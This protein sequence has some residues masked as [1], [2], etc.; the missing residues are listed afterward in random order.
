MLLNRQKKC[1]LDLPA[2]RAF[3]RRLRRALRLGYGDFNVC[4]VDD[5]E[6]E[7]LNRAFRGKPLAT[8]VLSFP[9]HESGEG[10]ILPQTSGGHPHKA[11]R[12]RE[13]FGKGQFKGFLGDVV[14][15]VEMARRNARSAR[16]SFRNELRWLIV[17][18]V[19]HLL[20][21]NHQMDQGEMTGL[22]RALRERLGIAGSPMKRSRK[23]RP[24]LSHG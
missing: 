6:I 3:T 13:G 22:E 4:F 10:A 1:A 7:R 19:L 11:G 15:S 16:H 14:I 21:Y 9:W 23:K 24:G 5:R 17:H 20:G 18:G 8:D 2:L 12:N